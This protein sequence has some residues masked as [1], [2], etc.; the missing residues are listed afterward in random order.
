MTITIPARMADLPRDRHDRLV[1]WFV[2]IIDGQPDHRV[3]DT[4]KFYR[5]L[6]AG[7]CWLCGGIL[8]RNKA[9]VLGPMC[10]VNR[11]TAEPPSHRDCALYAAIACPF[12][13]TPQMVRRDRGLPEDYTDPAGQMIL[14]NPGAVAVWITPTYTIKRLPDGLLIDIGDAQE[15]FWFAEGL[16]ATR[17]QVMASLDSGMPL[18]EEAAQAQGA[19]AVRQ[20]LDHEY[21]AAL[22]LLPS[23]DLTGRTS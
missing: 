2:A 18:L 11:V 8:G 17:S 9:F 15:V 22:A 12:L 16:P 20:L 5:A 4:A 14:R 7:L 19:H 1:P 13:T 10:A 23:D 21:P 6:K 3:A